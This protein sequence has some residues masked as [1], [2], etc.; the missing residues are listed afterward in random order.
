[1]PSSFEGAGHGHAYGAHGERLYTD[2]YGMQQ[3]PMIGGARGMM[4]GK[5]RVH[6]GGNISMQSDDN[7]SRISSGG[8]PYAY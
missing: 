4:Y 2:G 6:Y 5:Q 3:S 7:L 8:Q 1:M